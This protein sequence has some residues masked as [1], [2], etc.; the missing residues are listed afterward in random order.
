MNGKKAKKIR[1]I[2]R[3]LNINY[4][5]TKGNIAKDKRMRE[6]VNMMKI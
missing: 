6:L 3:K 2:C 5:R 4:K 1:R